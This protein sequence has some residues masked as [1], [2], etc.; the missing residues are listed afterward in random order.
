M[1]NKRLIVVVALMCSY[2]LFA[3]D[4]GD[5][6]VFIG[7]VEPGHATPAAVSPFG[8]V[9]AGPDTSLTER[10]FD[11]GKA[12]CSG[13]DYRDE[14]VWRFSQTHIEGTG[15]VSFGDFGLLPYVDGFDGRNRPARLLKDTET[16]E[17]GRYAVIL[18][19]GNARIGVEIVA[20][21][22]SAV[23]RF[24]FPKD[25]A[26]KLLVDLDW[27]LLDPSEDD[28][29]GKKVFSSTS[30]FP[31]EKTM[32]GGH[33]VKC[34]NEY[35]MHF[36]MDFSSP[37]VGRSRLRDADG[38]RG[39]IHELDFGILND[40]VL[41]VR[42]GL[43]YT[44]PRA[45]EKNMLEETGGIPFC[46]V[47]D[48]AR[49]E[50]R[51]VLSVVSLDPGTPSDVLKNFSAA[52]YRA[53]FQPNLISDVDQDPR[54]STFSLW[55]TFRAAHPLYTIL[56]ELQ[57]SDFVNS[58]LDQYDRQGYLPIWSL[59]GRE[60]HCMIGHHA[61]PV[62]VDAYLKG[63]KGVNWTRA[64]A[65]VRES[66][67]Q[68]H[69]AKGDG[70]WGL[71]KE[72]WDILDKYGYYPFDLMRG[73]YKGRP[74][75]GESVSRVLEC[76]YD[77]ACAVRFARGLG[78]AADA[79]FFGR[80]SANW[81]NVFDP[82]VGFMRGKDSKGKWREPFSPWD[83]GA[84]PW[85]EN[86]FCEGNSWQYTWHVMQDPDG[87]IAALGGREKF[88][89][90]LES[91]FGARP[92]S[93]ADGASYDVSGLIGQYAHGNEP[94]HHVIYFFTLAGRNDLA[95][96]YVRKV[97]ETQYQPR[98]DGLCGN[99]DCGQMAA[100]YVFSA[101]GFY[102]FDPCGGEYIIGA[103]QVPKVTLSFVD[104]KIFTM[105]AR[106]LSKE[107]KY[108]KSVMLNGKK[109]SDW[110]IH[111]ADIVKGGELVFEMMSRRE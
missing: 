109:I 100:W 18:K 2:C 81:K 73:E 45:A 84:G 67:T 107:N 30:E 21:P 87:L 27:G 22:R 102:P 10:R 14:W 35:E 63:V 88:V 37:V 79:E 93:D 52:F 58:L 9:Q 1:I 51:K 32:L 111:H 46:D 103:P 31:T 47:C 66:L 59:G 13:Y 71:L 80:R 53:H 50:W 95:A 39:E 105:T 68:N 89:A 57:V 11:P 26:A 4:P 23:Y 42:L 62:I 25:K 55:D 101:L 83:V 110:K 72:D 29:F 77:D 36:A 43:S 75:K 8:M 97:F 92:L 40:G 108:V 104:N 44:S 19:E 61:V 20:R 90:K 24:V 99:D 65:A 82:S 98:P 64:Y 6:D 54:Y 34:W 49:N 17:P 106:N 78:H 96:K 7:S 33:R 28:C 41:E 85:R 70:T 86:D 12:H 5:V 3:I 76:A 38:L 16:A 91:L 74:V 94:S 56:D 15:C 48:A 60:N 69:K